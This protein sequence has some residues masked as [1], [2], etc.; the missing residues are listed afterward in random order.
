MVVLQ[1]TP[2]SLPSLHPHQTWFVML[3]VELY[4]MVLTTVMAAV[5]MQMEFSKQE[6]LMLLQRFVLDLFQM[7][8]T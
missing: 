5:P 8:I 7:I 1:T 2:C 4:P 3:A 6:K